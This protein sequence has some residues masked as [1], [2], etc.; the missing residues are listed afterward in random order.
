MGDQ[1]VLANY[2]L[3]PDLQI[4]VKGLST[5]I[6]QSI[7]NAIAGIV[8]AFVGSEQFLDFRRMHRIIVASNLAAELAEL[9]NDTAS[10]API[11]HTNE[12]YA[13]AV[14]KVLML[15]REGTIEIVPVVSAQLA[16]DLVLNESSSS[17]NDRFRTAVHLIHHELCHVHD[18]NK[19]IDAF[20]GVFLKHSYTGKD[21]LIRPL[22]ETCWAEYIANRLSSATAPECFIANIVASFADAITR[23]KDLFDNEILAYRQHAD[24]DRLLG[25]FERHCGYLIKIASYTCGYLD[26]L[27]L[28]LHE[29]S[30]DTENV[31]RGS[32]I[33]QTWHVLRKSLVEM[34]SLYP[35]RWDSLTVFDLLADVVEAFYGKMGI[36]LSDLPNGKVYVAVPVR[37][38]N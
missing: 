1:Y 19:K 29:I 20:P 21:R 8:H 2:I 7:S 36:V 14:A 23:T 17:E 33:E 10:R 32:Y 12:E 5:E 18:D 31:L 13:V 24:I 4:S 28:N 22:A 37:T 35:A 30:A 11:T 27:N 25:C 3:E 9:S 16:Q 26:G 38:A 34:N 15:P 6:A